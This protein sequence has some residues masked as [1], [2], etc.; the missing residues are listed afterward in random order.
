MLHMVDSVGAPGEDGRLSLCW[1]RLRATQ[2]DDWHRKLVRELAAGHAG[3][4]DPASELEIALGR[5]RAAIAYALELARAHRVGAAGNAAG[6]DVWLQLGDGRVRFTL[7]RREGHLLFARAGAAAGAPVEVRLRWDDS[8]RA[9]V[10]GDGTRVDAGAAAREAIDALVA[11]WRMLPPRDRPPSA[12]PP[13]YDD[14]Q[15]TKG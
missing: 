8:A 2:M 6:D 3:E 1:R 10:D 13:D 12:P 5:A 4:P 7:N 11:A 9:I 14:E 15:P